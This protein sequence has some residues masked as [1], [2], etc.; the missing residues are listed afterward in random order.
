MLVSSGFGLTY[1]DAKDQFESWGWIVDT[2]RTF[3]TLYSCPNQEIQV[4]EPEFLIQNVDWAR[5][6]QYD[7]IF[8]P[9]GGHWDSLSTFI[10]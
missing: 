1:F 10:C 4:I 7:C 6:I 3:Q 5:F 8:V 9:S 2:A